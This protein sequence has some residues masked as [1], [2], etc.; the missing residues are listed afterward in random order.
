ML[1][2]HGDAGRMNLRETGIR[3]ERAFF[4]RAIRGGHIAAAG[5]GGK[6]KNI[7]ITAGSEHNRVGRILLDLS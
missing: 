6:I 5:V 4:K 3:E 1:A 2:A 7:S